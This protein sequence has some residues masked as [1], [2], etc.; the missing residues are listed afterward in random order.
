MTLW[1]ISGVSSSFIVSGS[2]NLSAPPPK[3]NYSWGETTFTESLV[4][5]W[6]DDSYAVNDSGMNV[7][8]SYQS[9][10]YSHN[11]TEGTF[12]KEIRTIYKYT[13]F[14]TNVNVTTSGNMTININIDA[15]QVNLD[16][17]Q[18]VD[19]MWFAAKNGSLEHEYYLSKRVEEYDY[20]EESHQRTE[21]LFNKFNYT[22]GE[23]MSTWN[24][25][26]DVYDEINITHTYR[27]EWYPFYEHTYYT[28]EF[29][30]PLIL[31][32]QIF[33]TQGNDRIA[34]ANLFYGMMIY[35]DEDQNGI[36]SVGN[37]PSWAG[38]PNIGA[39]T[40]MKGNLNPTAQSQYFLFEDNDSYYQE[41]FESSPTD[42]TTSEIASTLIFT[43]PFEVSET[44]VSWNIQY[45]NFPID[46]HF[47]DYDIP[48]DEWYSAPQNATYDELCP[49]NLSY[50]F[51][52]ILNETSA[53][54]DVTWELGKLTNDTAYNA[55]QGYGLVFPQY[56]YFL[57]TFDI[58][59]LNQQYLSFPKDKFTFQSNNTVVAEI[60][61][62]KKGKEN[63][64]LFDY[65]S[66]GIDTEL[67]SI[68][69]SI[70]K[71]AIG[72]SSKSSYYNNP[73]FA[74]L[75]SLDDIVAQDTSFVVQDDLFSMET[76]NYPIWNG[77]KLEHDPSL[78]IYFAGESSVDDSQVNDPIDL[79]PS[80]NLPIIIGVVSV[81]MVIIMKKL[82]TK[83]RI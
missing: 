44:E 46:M 16:Y 23:F 4:S 25:S 14:T 71:N 7:A 19:F 68:G 48:S 20:W 8:D 75:F 45:P 15:Y 47:F 52:F 10:H 5:Q 58:E 72:F 76:Q 59:E 34:W 80:Y 12:T 56:N 33:K 64:T 39:S 63:Y 22:T 60:N 30:T 81:V 51:D 62:G 49:T 13:N 83:H 78:S 28:S 32:L 3:L 73:F 82:R 55:I 50:G 67:L 17:G 36:L 6:V 65:P 11:A 9:Y 31:T 79:I 61:M 37:N 77:E 35:K 43:P 38:P 2:L 69:G 41:I 21:S 29:I 53:D 66:A 54:L 40:E 57:S 1:L 26:I 42:K 74:I 24:T 18:H 70:H 27:Q